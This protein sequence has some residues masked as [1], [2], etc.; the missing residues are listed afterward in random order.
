[1]PPEQSTYAQLSLAICQIF[2]LQIETCV[3]VCPG[4][5]QPLGH[6]VILNSE[7]DAIRLARRFP[8]ATMARRAVSSVAGG[9]VGLLASLQ[10]SVYLQILLL[11]LPHSRPV[12]PY[13]HTGRLI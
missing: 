11:Q 13:A 3:C 10:S 6:F 1:M 7:R 9:W 5:I 12:A 4:H 2:G 8:V